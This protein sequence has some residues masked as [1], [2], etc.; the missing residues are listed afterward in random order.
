MSKDKIEIKVSRGKRGPSRVQSILSV[1][2]LTKLPAN[3]GLLRRFMAL[4]K[5]DELHQ[6]IQQ[7]LQRK[8]AIVGLANTGKSTLFNTLRGQRHSAVSAEEGTTTT[9]IRGGFGPFTLIDTPGHL[10]DVQRAGIDEASVVL[11]L[12]DASRGIRPDDQA[13]LRDLQRTDKPLVIALNKVDTLRVDPDDVAGELAARLQVT[14]I[15]PISARDGTNVGDELVPALL[16]ASPEAA[17]T[18]GLAL[19]AFRRQAAARIVRNATLVSLAAGLEPIP[20]VD[21]PILLGNQIRLVLRIAALYGEP[22]TAQHTRELGSTIFGGLLLRYLGE[23]AAKAVPF[24]GDVVAGAIA[25]AGTWAI[26]Q[27]AIEY[28]EN[29][30][31]LS[32]EQIK[33]LFSR[34]YQRYRTDHLERELMPPSAKPAAGAESL[35][36]G[37]DIRRL[38]VASDAISPDGPS[39]GSAAS[40]TEQVPD[41]RA[42]G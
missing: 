29:G 5:W 7:D 23:Q 36:T 31:Q 32:R 34:Y 16:D 1:S 38:P 18:I 28:F 40:R 24:G 17:I 11:M 3:L 20:L 6:E 39:P 19:P 33:T 12:L 27:V 15:I 10:P 14:D 8:V 2:T 26:G 37:Q 9:L 42:T 25:A 4:T 30:K 21:I 22:M 13:L 35:P 41:E